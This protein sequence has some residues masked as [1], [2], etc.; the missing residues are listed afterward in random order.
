MLNVRNVINWA[1]PPGTVLFSYHMAWFR[2]WTLMLHYMH[3]VSACENLQSIVVVFQMMGEKFSAEW[4]SPPRS[5]SYKA[6]QLGAHSIMHPV[7]CSG[8]CGRCGWQPCHLG[9]EE[10]TRR[11]SGPLG[12]MR[13]VPLPVHRPR[14]LR[15]PLPGRHHQQR[16]QHWEDRWRGAG[17]RPS[18]SVSGM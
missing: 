4:V 9:R 16:C 14:A 17:I 13:R 1:E 2:R 5:K 7:G 11:L 6:V 8:L 3:S 10:A 15:G 12:G 18:R